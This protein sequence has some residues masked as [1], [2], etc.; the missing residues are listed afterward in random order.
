MVL[1][2]QLILSGGTEASLA[3]QKARFAEKTQ[4]LQRFL[5]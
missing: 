5:T 2:L 4:L 1:L 3:E